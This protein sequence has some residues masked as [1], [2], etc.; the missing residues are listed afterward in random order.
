MSASSSRAHRFLR[1][2]GQFIA[3]PESW[4]EG[5]E[6]HRAIHPSLLANRCACACSLCPQAK[7]EC[8][9]MLAI[10]GVLRKIP[11][12]QPFKKAKSGKKTDIFVNYCQPQSNK[13][14]NRAV[15]AQNTKPATFRPRAC[16][17]SRASSAC[18]PFGLYPHLPSESGPSPGFSATHRR[19]YRAPRPW[20]Q[21]FPRG[22]RGNWWQPPCPRPDS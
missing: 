9:N 11:R 12:S 13:Q 10:V 6:S 14:T 22:R 16:W 1:A 17:Q 7:A 4:T 5:V 15:L 8:A 20:A 18:E 2:K 19:Q 3:A 21:G